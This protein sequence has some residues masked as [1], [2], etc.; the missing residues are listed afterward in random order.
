MSPARRRP[1]R[2]SQIFRDIAEE[3]A[4]AERST[5]EARADHPSRA[6]GPV[7]PLAPRG[8]M[9]WTDRRIALTVATALAL[10]TVGVFALQHLFLHR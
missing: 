4:Q 8:R 3:E 6:P 9:F 1:P 10:G 2:P 5:G 7:A